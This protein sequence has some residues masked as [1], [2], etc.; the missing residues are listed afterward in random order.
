MSPRRP[1]RFSGLL[2]VAKVPGPT[3]HDVVDLARRALGE[4]RIGHTGTLDPMASGLLLLC[5]GHATRLQQ[6]LLDWDKTYRGTVRLGTATDTYDAQ[7]TP[8]APSGPVPGLDRARLDALEREFTGEIE[9]VPPPYSAKKVGGR[10]L[11]ELARSGERAEAEPK[12][13]RVTG[14]RLEAGG[15]GRLAFEVTCSSGFYVRSLAHDIGLRLGCGAYLERLER[16]SIGPYRVDDA[17]PQEELERAADPDAVL[18]GPA[19]IRLSEI[20]LPYPEVT[21]NPQAAERFGSGGEVVVLRTGTD[22]LVPG[23]P[24]VVRTRRGR[25]LGIGTVLHVLA[26]GRT[27]ALRPRTVLPTSA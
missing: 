2:P 25:L 24:V 1:P 17:L 22:A 20:R 12:R 19:W 8:I 7:G 9:Q 27:V 15:E 16:V 18:D 23:D 11:Y 14:L 26:R 10:K 5:V 3:S 13:V 21:L 4:R 6:Y